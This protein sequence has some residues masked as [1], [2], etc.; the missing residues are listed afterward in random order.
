VRELQA[1]TDRADIRALEDPVIPEALGF[2]RSSTRKMEG[3]IQAI[4]KLSRDGRRTLRPERLDILDV[5]ETSI[6]AIQHQVSEAEGAIALDINVPPIL[7]DRL[8][9]EQTFGNLLDNAVKYR[10][11]DRPLRIDVRA[12]V[13]SDSLFT[14]EVA[15]NGRGIAEADQAGIFELFQRLGEADQ[16]GEGIGLA[17]VQTLVRNLGGDIGVVSAPGKGTTFRIVL[18]RQLDLPAASTTGI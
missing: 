15:D 1:L 16:P 13:L 10:A 14:V 4:L 9:L 12:D 11:K 7:G 6:Q 18:P 5:V 8:S 17:Y 3:L 2:I